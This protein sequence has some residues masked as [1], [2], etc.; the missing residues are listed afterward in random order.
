MSTVTDECQLKDQVAWRPGSI[1]PGRVDAV[2]RA[3]G[4]PIVETVE[5]LL[6][7]KHAAILVTGMSGVGKS[8]ALA[9]LA[10][11]G[12]ATVD[13]DEGPWIQVV[14][15][16]PLWREALIDALLDQP[17]QSPLFVQGTVANQGRFYD[18]FDAIVLLSA[19]MDVVFDRVARRTHNPFGKTAAERARIADDIEN[20]EPLLRQ[21]ATHEIDTARP[22]AEVIDMLN[23]IAWKVAPH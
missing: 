20:V 5:L 14:D 11:R 13:T 2:C 21:A 3:G 6:V 19:P 7:P 4:A 23:R 9:E 22:L 16:E 10:K 1:L 12:F 18:R 15:G 8:T 17:R